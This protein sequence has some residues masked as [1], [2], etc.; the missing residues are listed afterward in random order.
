M[1][2]LGWAPNHRSRLLDSFT[3]Q[4]PCAQVETRR[5]WWGFPWGWSD[6]D[7]LPRGT[8][9][10]WKRNGTYMV[11]WRTWLHCLRSA[12]SWCCLV[13]FCLCCPCLFGS[14]RLYLCP[15]P[16]RCICRLQSSYCYQMHWHQSQMCILSRG[17]HDLFCQDFLELIG[18][19]LLHHHQRFPLEE[20]ATPR[21]SGNGLHVSDRWLSWW[22]LCLP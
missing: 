11:S 6:L 3:P 16:S 18:D 2:L 14:Q 5:G 15:C 13:G 17:L 7:Q 4:P 21:T 10:R 19:H 22:C 9:S 1:V 12:A 20:F 8:L